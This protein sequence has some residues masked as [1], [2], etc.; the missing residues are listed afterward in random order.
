M[1]SDHEIALQL[2]AEVNEVRHCPLAFIG[3]Y[4]DGSGFYQSSPTSKPLF[5]FENSQDLIEK[6]YLVK[7]TLRSWKV[8][9]VITIEEQ[10]LDQCVSVSVKMIARYIEQRLGI[11][12]LNGEINKEV[13]EYWERIILDMIKENQK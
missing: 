10:I 5:R 13:L 8:E 3:T 12:K 1:K 2:L 9:P 6:L 11:E 7:T 4:A